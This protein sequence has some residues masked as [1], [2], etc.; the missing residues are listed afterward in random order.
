VGALL[1]LQALE[2]QSM[3][4]D[5]YGHALASGSLD[6]PVEDQLRQG[7]RAMLGAYLDLV[8]SIPEHRGRFVQRQTEIVRAMVEAVDELR[9]RFAEPSRK[10][11]GPRERQVRHDG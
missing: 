10:T 11:A 2:W 1:L 8:K 4:L 5:L 9:G 6:A 3:A 7:A